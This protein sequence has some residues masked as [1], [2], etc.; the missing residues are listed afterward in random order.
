M[1]VVCQNAGETEQEG[2][3]TVQRAGDRPYVAYMLR[4]WRVEEPTGVTLRASLEHAHSGERQSFSDL[5]ALCTYLRE[6]VRIQERHHPGKKE[7]RD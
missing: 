4:I 6:H 5:E 1:T 2:G 3:I 7:G